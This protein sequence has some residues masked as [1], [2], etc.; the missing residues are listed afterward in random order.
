MKRR[1][2]K[3]TAHYFMLGE[4][5]LLRRTKNGLHTIPN[6]K[7][8]P[9]ILKTFR[10]YFCHWNTETTKSFVVT[11]FWWPLVYLNIE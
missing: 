11:Q 7:E 3:H 10:D 8:S 2:I 5:K 4:A 6:I 9:A 1:S